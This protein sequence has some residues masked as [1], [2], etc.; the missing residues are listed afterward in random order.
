MSTPTWADLVAAE[1]ELRVLLAD[2]RRVTPG[3]DFCANAVWYGYGDPA[4]G[5]RER[6]GNL[7]GWTARQQTPLLRSSAAC[8]CAYDTCYGALPNC[9]HPGGC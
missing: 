8:D 5:F 2:I 1:P 9:E 7:V 4:G 6:L 3:P